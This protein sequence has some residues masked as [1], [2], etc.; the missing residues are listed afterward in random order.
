METFAVTAGRRVRN[1]GAS[2]LLPFVAR[3]L[4]RASARASSLRE[5]VDLAF[6]FGR[7]HFRIA[8]HQV[9]AEILRLLEI[10][11]DLRPRRLVEI[12]TAR[13]GTLFLLAR[14]AAPDAVLVSLDLPW[15]PD[16]GY[17]RWRRAY[18]RSF[19]LPGQRIVTLQGDSHEEATRAL[20][21]A[22]LGREPLDFLLIDGDHSR[23]G[24]EDDWRRYS[25]LVRPGGLVAFHDIAPGPQALV[26]GVPEFW[27]QL[28]ATARTEEI[29]DTEGQEG[30][31][32]G[33]V[34]MPAAPPR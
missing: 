32:L 24:V 13:G 2:L 10:V 33:L 8:P 7:R 18:Y 14:A 4:R 31:G 9:P 16:A 20:V 6:R 34:T 28:R 15:R 17:P 23:Q 26:G 12:G 3:D 22:A 21:E 1:L 19:A 5:Q 27:R 11:R 29:V 25:P 30:C